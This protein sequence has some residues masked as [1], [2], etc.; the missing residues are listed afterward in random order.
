M[1]TTNVGF[2]LDFE[3]RQLHEATRRGC[4]LLSIRVVADEALI[5]PRWIPGQRSACAG[6]AEAR[7]RQSVDHPLRR[8]GD[9]NASPRSGWPAALEVLVDVALNHLAVH[10]LEPGEML[11]VGLARTSRHRVLRSMACP[12]C[13]PRSGATP[14]S[15]GCVPTDRPEALAFQPRA[16]G[17][18]V[19][20]RGVRS[21]AIEEA[22]LP[23]LV[24]YRFGPVVQVRRDNRA[25]FAMSGALVPGS[26]AM[27]YGRGGDFARAGA[28][29]ILE[30]YERLGA[31]PHQGQVI[32]DLSYNEVRDLAVDPDT[33]GRYSR[34]QL[35]HPNGQV[36]A[37]RPDVAMDW[38]FGH[39]LDDGE[40]WL[41]PADV[42]FYGYE[43]QRRL[44]EPSAVVDG[45]RAEGRRRHFF[46]ESSSGCALGSSL[47]EAAL[48]ALVELI[49]RDAF[50]LAWCRR[51][52]LPAIDQGSI[53]D[54]T[55]TMMLDAIDGHGFDVHVLSTT[56]DLG[57]PSV[58]AL[59][60]NRDPSAVPATFSAAGSSP[61]PADALRAALWELAQ[62]V[63]HPVDWDV[64]AVHRLVDDP[65]LVDTIEDHVHLYAMPAMRDR[66]CQVLGG[67]VVAMA[68]AFPGWPEQLCQAAQGDVRG[69]LDYLLSQ[70]RAA[71][72][73]TAL[74]VDQSTQ[75]HRDLG[76]AVARVVVP[77]ML[78]MCFGS[79]QQRLGGLPR[80]ELALAATAWA[81]V[82]LMLDPHPFP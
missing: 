10:P 4:Q 37:Y 29:A 68:S 22:E 59:A 76:L 6:C 79:P 14:I 69:A 78:P 20:L 80:R 70:C 63:A 60:V 8:R 57:V 21:P 61:V 32:Q 5:G 24:D 42:A 25:P 27:G 11:S 75:E 73:E 48:H 13:G 9:L 26:R 71:G 35:D 64:D 46:A 36:M 15:R 67:P 58:W 17:D 54:P 52:P 81:D 38:A 34:A 33:L 12:I 40:A 65:S 45:G 77:G 39:R 49:E 7:L 3:A 53:D 51:A 31:F 23:R 66:V 41:L 30:A 16:S 1:V 62:L 56:Y 19:P 82:D 18:R 74:V 44:D 50:L 28:V 43:Y 72:L 47:E 55:S 2:D